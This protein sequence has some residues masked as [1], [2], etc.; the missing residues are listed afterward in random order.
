MACICDS[1]WQSVAP[2]PPCPVHG[3]R[4]WLTDGVQ[5]FG[6]YPVR[7]TNGTSSASSKMLTL[8]I[9]G[10]ASRAAYYQPDRTERLLGWA[11]ALLH[12]VPFRVP[13]QRWICDAYDRKVIASA[14]RAMP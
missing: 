9:T 2:P 4:L 12:R 7:A 5:T 8:T 11:D 6:S 10:G 1:I 13:G 3:P 14:E